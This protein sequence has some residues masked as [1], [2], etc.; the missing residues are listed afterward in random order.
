MTASPLELALGG[1]CLALIIVLVLILAWSRRYRR[2][3]IQ[4]TLE[5]QRDEH[6]DANP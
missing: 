5:V 2:T 4:L 1:I 6:T 3:R